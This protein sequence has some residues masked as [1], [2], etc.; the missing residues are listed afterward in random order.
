[1]SREEALRQFHVATGC[2]D[3]AQATAILEACEWNVESAVNTYKFQFSAVNSPTVVGTP[4]YAAPYPQQ[5]PYPT[6][7]YVNGAYPSGQYPP[8]QYPPQYVAGAYPPGQPYYYDG[9]AAAYNQGYY[10]A[11]RRQAAQDECCCIGLLLL[12]CCC[13]F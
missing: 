5:Q 8:G 10:Q 11:Q 2:T 7:V 12:C 9:N 4:V 6:N 13:I 1:M 3:Q